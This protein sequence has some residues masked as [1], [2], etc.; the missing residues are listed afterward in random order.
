[1]VATDSA[2][3]PWH[4]QSLTGSPPPVA[5]NPDSQ[6]AL[7][8]LSPEDAESSGFQPFGSDGFSFL[9]LLDV[10]NPLQHIPIVG[11]LYRQFTGDT[12]DPLPRIAGS[13]FFFGPVGAAVSGANV[14]LQEASG[15]DVGEHVMALLRDEGSGLQTADAQ[16][17]Q[18]SP[19]DVSV[20]AKEPIAAGTDGEFQG[21]DPITAWARGELAYREG[22]AR[23]QTAA[24]M[25][26]INQPENSGQKSNR[27]SWASDSLV[28]DSTAP[29]SRV[30]LQ[31]SAIQASAAHAYETARLSA[32]S[33]TSKP[34]RPDGVG[35]TA[36]GGG[37]FAA[38]LIDTLNRYNRQQTALERQAAPVE[39]QVIN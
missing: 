39:N 16:D 18:P 12:I 2:I 8:E 24:G 31:T 38:N 14:V 26:P 32:T 25:A 21:E 4:R 34:P 22:L 29:N 10:V 30:A 5:A 6:Q 35:A 20:V 9:D 27:L 11:T 1:M 7:S 33:P 23:T 36:P 17:A 37:W 13:T 3:L 19:H 28:P 15:R